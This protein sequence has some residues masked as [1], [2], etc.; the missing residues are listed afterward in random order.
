MKIRYRRGF[1]LVETLIVLSILS[2]LSIIFVQIFFRTLRGGNKAQIV[3]IVKQNGQAALETMDK[4]I[5]SAD[6]VICPESNTALDTLVIQK[7]TTFTRFKFN[8]PVAAPA[9]NGFISQDNVGDCTS[10]LG[11][12][13]AS[14]TNL[15]TTNGASVSGGSFSRNSQSGFNDLVTIS[16]NIGPAV[17]VPKTLTDTIDPINLYTTVQLR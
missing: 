7:D 1:T 8:P 17:A 4:A 14:L 10:P 5:R 16:F 2:I 13:Y 15:S 11:A 6:K 9:S 3:G 12:N